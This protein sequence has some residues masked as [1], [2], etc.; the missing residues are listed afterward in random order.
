MV[1]RLALPI[2]KEENFK[3]FFDNWFTSVPLAVTLAEQ[4]IQCTGTVRGN[5][6]PGVNL[7]SD[8]DLKRVGR[9]AFEEKMAMVTETTLHVVK[10]YD[11][12][13]VA[14][15]SDHIRANPVTE[16]QR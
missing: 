3:L 11:N 4:G 14:L 6:L 1:L 15:L 2:P 10:W 13:S 12:R 8:A 5:R 9:G 7:K 16:V